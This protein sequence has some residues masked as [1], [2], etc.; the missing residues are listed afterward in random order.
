MVFCLNLLAS[1]TISYKQIKFDGLTQISNNIALQTLDLDNSHQITNRQINKAIKDFY[2][3][4]YFTDIWVTQQDDILTFHFKEKPFI[5]NL[6]MTGYKTRKEDL[7]LLY[8]AMGIK[9]GKMY[10]PELISRA[11]KMLLLALQ[12][13]GYINSVVEVTTKQIN[14]TSLTVKFDV[15]KGKPIVIKKMIFKGAKNLTEDDFK[16][17][18]I[19]KQEDCCFTWF[20]EEMMER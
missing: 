17:V 3:F 15:N 20:L 8:N 19:N 16:E 13:E 11:K 5:A 14:Q 7:E 1:D 9:K 4:D 10:S 6:E 12:Q 18:L 2:K